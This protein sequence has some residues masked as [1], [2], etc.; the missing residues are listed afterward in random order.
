MGT[1][2]AGEDRVKHQGSQKV[3]CSASACIESIQLME[4]ITYS[5]FTKRNYIETITHNVVRADKFP[6]EGGN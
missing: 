3:D 5:R 1:D 2:P 4:I 6:N